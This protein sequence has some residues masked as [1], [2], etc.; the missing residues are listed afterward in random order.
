MDSL[1]KELGFGVKCFMPG[2]IA[3]PPRLEI[4]I[5][6]LKTYLN[7]ALKLHDK[8]EYFCVFLLALLEE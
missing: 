6:K 4:D 5:K 7:W 2:T 8:G 1:E 3:V